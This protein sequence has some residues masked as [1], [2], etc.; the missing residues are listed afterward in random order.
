MKRYIQL[1]W[2]TLV[3]LFFTPLSYGASCSVHGESDFTISFR[4]TGSNTY[5]QFYLKQGSHGHVHGFPA[6]DKTVGKYLN[7]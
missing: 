4:V 7:Q 5:Q 2:L 3:M 1:L 6:L